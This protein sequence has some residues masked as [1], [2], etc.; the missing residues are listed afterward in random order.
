MH[1][2][3]GRD[4][5]LRETVENIELGDGERGE[6]VNHVTVAEH[7]DVEPPAATRSSRRHAVLVTYTLEPLTDLLQQRG[8]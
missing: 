7:D 2:V 4:L 5:H 3:G 6:P 8:Y 1:A